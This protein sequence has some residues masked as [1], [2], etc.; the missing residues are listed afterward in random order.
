MNF[1]SLYFWDSSKATSYFQPSV[2][3]QHAHFISQTVCSPVINTLS[4]WGPRV[5]FTLQVTEWWETFVKGN[6]RSIFDVFK[7]DFSW[8]RRL[9]RCWKGRRVHASLEMPEPSTKMANVWVQGTLTDG[10]TL[11]R[12]SPRISKTRLRDQL[13]MV[14]CVRPTCATSV[15]SISRQVLFEKHPHWVCEKGKTA[16]EGFTRQRIWNQTLCSTPRTKIQ[17]TQVGLPQLQM[18]SLKDGEC[19][20]SDGGTSTFGTNDILKLRR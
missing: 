19:N 18:H 6:K 17:G 2:D 8:R 10:A 16:S 4:S 7:V 12:K 9:T 20:P 11:P 5:T 15:N 13:L 14:S 1:P 3:P